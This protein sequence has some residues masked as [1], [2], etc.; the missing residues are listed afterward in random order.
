M[1]TAAAAHTRDASDQQTSLHAAQQE[2]L[3][4]GVNR[5]AAAIGRAIKDRSDRHDGERQRRTAEHDTALTEGLP[6]HQATAI[7]VRLP[8]LSDTPEAGRRWLPLRCSVGTFG[9]A[10]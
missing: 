9:I 3:N 8:L 1:P 5:D 2:E 6:V 10:R 4:V 7:T